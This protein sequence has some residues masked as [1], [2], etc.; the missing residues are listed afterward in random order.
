MCAM[1]LLQAESN[2]G[3]SVPGTIEPRNFSVR[4][5]V[6]WLLQ[7]LQPGVSVIAG[8]RWTPQG[9]R[10]CTSSG[11]FVFLQGKGTRVWLACAQEGM[12]LL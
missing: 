8:R 3:H 10:Q 5:P 9:C 1:Q 7:A 11:S 12:P 2:L 6:R 4:G